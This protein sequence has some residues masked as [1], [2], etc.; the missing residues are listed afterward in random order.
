MTPF[1]AGQIE[2]EEPDWPERFEDHC[3]RWPNLPRY[4]AEDSAFEAT[5]TDWRRF[6][7]TPI[8]VEGKTKTKPAPAVDGMI[9][10]AKLRIF[11]PRNLIKDV[12]RDGVAGFQADDHMWLS[13]AGEQ[14][15]IT[16]I[17]DRMLLLER[18]FSDAPE[19]KQ[20]DLGRAKWDK[21][22]EAAV[23]MLEA[24][25]AIDGD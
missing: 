9:A 3:L 23:S 24:I 21:Y 19:T 17:E 8:V 13:I 14:W 15:R 2:F 16:A 1:E 10:L 11:P 25:K 6:H 5:L 4:L 7:G 22:I 20:I 18:G 12:P